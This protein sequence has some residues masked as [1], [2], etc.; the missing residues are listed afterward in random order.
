MKIPLAGVIGAPV[1]HS[2][3]PAL[4]GYWLR[5]YGIAG[6]YVPLEIAGPDLSQVLRAL[7][8]AGFVGCNV[9]IPHKEAVLSLADTVSDQARRI[10]AANT[11]SFDENGFYADNTDGY[12][13]ITNLMQGA[14]GWDPLAGPVAVIGAGGAARA[15]VVALAEAG[16]QEIRIANRTAARADALAAEFGLTPVRWSE[17]AD[18]LEGATL[19]VNTSAMG[20]VGQEPLDLTLDRLSAAAVVTDIVYTPLQTPLLQAAAAHGCVTV[21]GLGM[22]LHQAVPG[23]ER[24]FG[25]RPEVTAD[26]RRAVLA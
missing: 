22:L 9:T 10:G 13:F 21:D 16:C 7:P 19:V 17:R 23:F 12:G 2:R 5:H 26:L 6:H 18:M 3:S 1:G 15:V 20:M 8:K 14:P 4:H 25:R 24:W 11:L